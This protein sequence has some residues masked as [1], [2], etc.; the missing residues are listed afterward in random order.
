MTEALRRCLALEDEEVVGCVAQLAT[1]SDGAL[2]RLLSASYRGMMPLLVTRTP[3]AQKRVTQHLAKHKVGRDSDPPARG[4]CLMPGGSQFVRYVA[5][6]PQGK[7]HEMSRYVG[8]LWRCVLLATHNACA[9]PGGTLHAVI[10][11][12][13]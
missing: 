2:A 5:Y 3:A 10:H 7:A 11:G 9:M 8:P 6:C 4:H 1:V 12:Q 13:Y